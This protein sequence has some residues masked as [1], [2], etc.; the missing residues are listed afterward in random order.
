MNENIFLQLQH[1][2]SKTQSLIAFSLKNFGYMQEHIRNDN[3]TGKK[4]KVRII[5]FS[6]PKSEFHY[7][8]PLQKLFIY[9]FSSHEH[10]TLNSFLSSSFSQS[11]LF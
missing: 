6:R 10:R 3:K 8:L 4:L 2:E 7:Q 11:D 1:V 5:F 9:G